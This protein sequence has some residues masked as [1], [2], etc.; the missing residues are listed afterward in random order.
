MRAN[1]AHAV[2]TRCALF[3]SRFVYSC[4]YHSRKQLK[5]FLLQNKFK[6]TNR[7]KGRFRI[8]LV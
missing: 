3:P 1:I 6:K 7:E 5:Y 2:F 8:T 4:L